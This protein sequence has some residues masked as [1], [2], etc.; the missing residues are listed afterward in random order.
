MER[1]F[2]IM[3]A[4]CPLARA[5][6]LVESAIT[7]SMLNAPLQVIVEV[8]RLSVS[9]QPQI[10]TIAEVEVVSVIR[11]TIRSPNGVK[12]NDIITIEIP[13]GDSGQGFLHYSG[14]VYPSL[15]RRYEVVLAPTDHFTYKVVGFERGFKSLSNERHFVRNQ[16]GCANSNPAYVHWNSR[17][18]PIPYFISVDSFRTN[19]ELVNG[20][21]ASFESWRNIDGVGVDFIPMGCTKSRLNE[22]D[23]INSL[24][25]VTDSWAF[26]PEAIAVTRNFFVGCESPYAGTILDSD[27][28]INGVNHSFTVGASPGAHDIQNILTH[29]IG[30]FLGLGHETSDGD[31]ETAMWAS[32]DFSET[33]KRTPKTSDIDGIRGIY[34]L[35]IVKGLPNPGVDCPIPSL[36]TYGCASAKNRQGQPSDLIPL[37][38]ILIIPLLR[39]CRKALH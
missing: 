5:L 12:A 6:T 19:P 4:L 24:V 21:R 11:S 8:N 27:I 20:I 3:I 1:I 16:V 2:I 14:V 9:T 39:L 32:A 35:E 7:Q 38:L 26:Q 30:H 15:H 25:F 33:K 36:A 10:V 37:L 18:M 13:G 23:G 17:F 29:E 34:P 28:L 31:P 22:N